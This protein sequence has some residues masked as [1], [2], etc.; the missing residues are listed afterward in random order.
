MAF[1]VNEKKEKE[2]K[3]EEKVIKRGNKDIKRGPRKG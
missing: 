3:D 1:R 2:L